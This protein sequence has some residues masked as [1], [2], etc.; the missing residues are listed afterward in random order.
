MSIEKI[1]AEAIDNNPL[2]MKEAFEE[3]MNSRIRASL[4]EKYKEMTEGKVKEDEDED[5]EDE[6]EDESDEEEDEDEDESDEEESKS[7]KKVSEHT[8]T[9][10]WSHM[11]SEEVIDIDYIGDDKHKADAEKKYRVKI[12]KTGDDT[13]DVSGDAKDLWKFA[14][15]HYH[16]DEEEAADIHPKLAKA[17]GYEVK[18]EE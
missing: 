18:D 3:E 2:K 6:D 5:E 15:N 10:D 13:A 12:K 11:L 9:I 1:I 4:E 17:A 8:I 14:V 16:N 7:K